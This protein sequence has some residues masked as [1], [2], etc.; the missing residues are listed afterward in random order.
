MHDLRRDV[1]KILCLLLQTSPAFPAGPAAPYGPAAAFLTPTASPPASATDAIAASTP[2][3]AT[4]AV[5]AAAAAA[6]SAL[7]SPFAVI[8]S[9][10]TPCQGNLR[11]PSNGWGRGGGRGEGTGG[12]MQG[13]GTEGG[14]GA[15]VRGEEGGG[16][17]KVVGAGA[18]A[19][20]VVLHP[21]TPA[22]ATAPPPPLWKGPPP[23]PTTATSPPLS[24]GGA[25]S[26][27]EM[28]ASM[29]FSPPVHRS[30]DATAAAGVTREGPTEPAPGRRNDGVRAP[31]RQLSAPPRPAPGGDASWWKGGSAGAGV[32]SLYRCVSGEDGAGLAGLGWFCSEDE[33]GLGG[34]G[35]G[36][37]LLTRARTTGPGPGPHVSCPA[38]AA[39]A[40]PTSP[41]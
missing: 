35:G 27:P 17:C 41:R 16:G 36:A 12:E 2:A 29:V 3:F 38:G 22:P 23:T 37:G 33:T 11:L 26:P 34:R 24:L 21:P 1:T 14:V 40:G 18:E 39:D 5:A 9:N 6:S 4:D 13:G 28:W 20:R 10:P 25:P 19:P 30:A 7:G 31:P 8:V 15:T 32:E